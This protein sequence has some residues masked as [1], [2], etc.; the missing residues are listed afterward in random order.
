MRALS[1]P[2]VAK[3]GVLATPET[4][5]QLKGFVPAGVI[6]PRHPR[7]SCR[8]CACL[9]DSSPISEA[10]QFRALAAPRPATRGEGSRPDSAGY[11][12]GGPELLVAEAA[13]QRPPTAGDVRHLCDG[14]HLLGAADAHLGRETAGRGGGLSGQAG[15][16]WPR[17]SDPSLSG[18][19]QTGQ[20]KG[21]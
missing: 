11:L 13:H 10:S 21:A 19:P 18:A 3:A 16:G 8:P 9:L 15:R 1:W 7:A 12:D 4:T 14:L 2:V 17:L 20:C 6:P 5:R